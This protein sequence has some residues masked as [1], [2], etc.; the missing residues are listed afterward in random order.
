V[1]YNLIRHACLEIMDT[2]AINSWM[3]QPASKDAERDGHLIRFNY[4]ADTFAF[5]AADGKV[6]KGP[7]SW[8]NGIY[9][10][11]YTSNCLIYGNIIVRSLIQ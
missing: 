10:D 5:Q 6:G 1:E 2:G 7:N 11:N 4:I 3:E 8:S 9:L